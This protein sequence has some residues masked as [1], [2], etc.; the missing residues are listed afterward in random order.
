[1]SNWKEQFP[2]QILQRGKKYYREGRVFLTSLYSQKKFAGLVNG[3]QQYHVTGTF[4]KGETTDL[5]CDCPYAAGGHICK[6]MAAV[7]LALE[8]DR[9]PKPT[10]GQRQR[11]R[12]YLGPRLDLS[13]LPINPAQLVG[14]YYF[15]R[16]IIGEALDR[17]DSLNILIETINDLVIFDGWQEQSWVYY[18]AASFADKAFLV[19][20]TFHRK[21]I[22][23]I[24]ISCFPDASKEDKQLVKAIGLLRLATCIANHDFG[25]GA[26]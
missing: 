18:L 17:L 8:H 21:K 22:R 12:R 10:S 1:M 25:D 23:G 3:R 16:V 9:Q 7:L 6:H 26:I 24:S 5:Q 15:P 2:A 4:E 20:I 11:L 19:I 14:N 13:F